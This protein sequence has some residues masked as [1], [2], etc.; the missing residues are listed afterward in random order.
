M[1]YKKIIPTLAFTT[2]L[3]A[4][5]DDSK[6]EWETRDPDSQITISEI[7][8]SLAEKIARYDVLKSYS[9]MT[10]GVGIDLALYMEN[11]TYAQI[12]N[13]NFDEIT[14]GYHM[15]H[16]PMVGSNGKIG[17]DRVDA[18]IE[19]LKAAGLST[20][21]H[22]LVWHQNQNASY[23]NG[24][25]V[26]TVIPGP[27]GSNALDISG[28]E[29]GSFTGWGRPNLGAGITIED[30]AGLSNSAKALKLVSG[31]SSSAAYNLQLQTPSI[32]VVSGHNY[33]ISFYIK[34]DKTGKG[35]VSFNGLSNNYPYKDWYATGAN[36]TEAF[37]TTSTW[38]QVKITINDFTGNSFLFN[39]DLGYLPDVTYYIDVATI[40][41]VDLDAEPEVVNMLANGNFDTDLTGWSAWNGGASSLAHVTG[42]DAL[43]GNGAMKVIT[44]TAGDYWSVQIHSNFT[45]TLA[46][47]DYKLSFYIK[48]DAT[49]LVRC[50]TTGTT[51]YQGDQATSST[52]KLV[53]WTFTSDGA[54]TG[55]N[56]D[57]GKTPATYF[58]DN[59]VVSP[60]S[61]AATAPKLKVAKAGAVYLEKTDEEKAQLIGDAMESFISQMVEHYKA[62][63][64]AWDVV[65]E[66]MK[67]DGTLRD[68][69]VTDPANDEFYWVKYLGKDYAVT[70]FR[71]A[72]QHGNPSDVLFINDYN[73]EHSL[74][75]C[76]GL[77]D[78]VTY[79]ESQGVQV[80]GIGTQMHININT[81]KGNITEMFNLLAA[82][83][84]KIKISELDI[85][86]LTNAP[87]AEQYAAQAGMY[88][89]VVDQYRTII[90]VA[91]QY[92]ITAWGVSD[93]TE[94]HVNWLPDDAPN[95]WNAKYERKQAY[96][97]F[98]DGLAG[99]D[100]SEDFTGEL[101][102]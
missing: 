68:G 83:G 7:P 99:R 54:I 29:D 67:E 21:G 23:L 41:V 73:L 47:G 97:S 24:L 13:D 26:P 40:V 14:I 84:K 50:S 48:S 53:E 77:I 74:A 37:A 70:A 79:I 92:G 81:N 51:K 31:P 32:P 45:E 87:S 4:A 6:M 39:F 101:D 75:K 102:Y 15:K 59:V 44:S 12:V 19:K 57:L 62:D 80:D 91:Q 98:A 100:V 63:V 8:L 52:W 46:A 3:A 65:N 5:C 69:N 9:D 61:S 60:V 18:M 20:F 2:L 93:A 89:F 42:S 96:K 30:G 16:G 33:Q 55:I 11:G 64:H 49:G 82:T 71:L 17:F 38:Q 95:L 27:A 58:I 86:V 43:E 76:Q 22:T 72:R 34:S 10:V 36:W 1:N 25:I 66:P 56:F 28:L 90:P 94:E 35:R 85:Q 88:Q 78:Y